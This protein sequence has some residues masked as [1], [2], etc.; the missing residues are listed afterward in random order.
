MRKKKEK[1]EDYIFWNSW[2]DV[3]FES[4]I[5]VA[6]AIFI[7]I[8]YTES[9]TDSYGIGVQTGFCLAGIFFYFILPV[10]VF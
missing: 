8:S 1:L 3:V 4:M 2:I 10:I 9:F 6:V 7:T 5:F